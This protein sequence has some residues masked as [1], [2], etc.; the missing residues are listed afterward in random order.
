MKYPNLFK[1]RYPELKGSDWLNFVSEEDRKAFIELGFSHSD[2]GRLGGKAL[3]EQRGVGYMREI[4][5][6]GALVRNMKREIAQAIEQ[7]SESV[8]F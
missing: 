4:G 5:R 3:V 2:F 6:R 1:D 7:E 8:D